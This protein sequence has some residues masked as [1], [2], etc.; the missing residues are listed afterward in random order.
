[1]SFEDISGNDDRREPEVQQESI[2]TTPYFTFAILTCIIAVFAAQQMIPGEEV[3]FLASFD[4]RYFLDGDYWRIL[5]GV[6]VHGGIFH[7]LFNGYALFVLGRLSEILSAKP[8][9][10]I[11]FLISAIAGGILS[12]IF[13]PDVRSVG[14]SGGVIGLLGYLTIYSYRR[15]ELLSSSLFNNM[16]LNIGIIGF[17]GVF[18]IPNVDNYGHLGGLIAGF[19]YGVFEVPDDLRVDPREHGSVRQYLAYA[20]IGVV[21]LTSLFTITLFTLRFFGVELWLE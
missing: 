11:V 21:V 2:Q 19:L 4:K 8:N 13:I 12:L 20:A 7:I 6:V 3:S 9:V 5:T 18:V 16:L 1:M 15:R 10:P 14:A 17:L